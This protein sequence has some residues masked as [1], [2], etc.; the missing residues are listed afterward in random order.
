MIKLNIKMTKDG[1][2]V[3][4]FLDSKG[5]RVRVG[6]A[7]QDWV[8]ARQLTELAL[9][10]I[11]LQRE[12]AAAMIGSDGGQM[13]AL[14]SRYAVWK[15]KVGLNPK[16]DLYGLGGLVLSSR[17]K[18][19]K[20]LR[21]GNAITRAASGGRGHMLDDLRIN[22]VGDKQVTFGITTSASRVKAL[23]NEQKAPWYGLSPA[24]AIK[25]N[26]RMAQLFGTGVGEYLLS[27][28][29]AGASAVASAGR[30]LKKAA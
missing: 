8:K 27:V 1:R 21:S 7:S 19:K 24:N 20:Y 28:G 10:A 17:A 11:Q 9:Y 13:P 23:A 6:S 2:E 5:R 26:L 30:F 29:L 14:K 12:Q 25:M 22:Y 15:E 16:R 18:G 4:S 3:T